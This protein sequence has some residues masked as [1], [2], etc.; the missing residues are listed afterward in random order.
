MIDKNKSYK[1]IVGFL[2]QKYPISL[3][4][5]WDNN[6]LFI[7]PDRETVSSIALTL[8]LTES[9]IEK[10]IAKKINFIISHHPL[11]LSGLKTIDSKTREGNL[12]IQL[13]K[14]GIG[15]YV[16][17][18]SFDYHAEGLN[19]Y[20]GKAIGL[21]KMEPLKPIDEDAY[22]KLEFYI[23]KENE[24]AAFKALYSL[25]ASTFN[26]YDSCYFALRG[27]D[28]FGDF[29]NN[30]STIS[31]V[32]ESTITNKV[33]VEMI[34]PKNKVVEIVK[35]LKRIHPCKDVT[36]Y[37]YSIIFNEKKNG[38]GK[39]GILRKAEKL[40]EFMKR[41]KLI[42]GCESIEITYPLNDIIIKRVSIC[43]GSGKHLLPIAIKRSD[44]YLTGDLSYHDFEKA[45]YCKFPLG[46]IGH[47][48]SERLG[49]IGWSEMLSRQLDVAVY[50]LEE[51][52]YSTII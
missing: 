29:E 50:F 25:G 41:V 30:N 14:N 43:G 1:K 2:N 3:S 35:T 26:N 32:E 52:M 40:S 16:A 44:I 18:T 27:F 47:F 8:S 21:S 17:H 23:P 45:A 34:I 49:L 33:K 20:L 46:N 13:I 38:L 36:Y 39:V 37:L 48:Y 10:A 24:R 42:L 15:L 11:T 5:K 19:Y 31:K 51:G 7:P 12:L 22:L 6:G 4:E 28:S 9:V